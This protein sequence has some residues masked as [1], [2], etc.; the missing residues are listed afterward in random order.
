[1]WKQIPYPENHL[2]PRVL[3]KICL[4]HSKGAG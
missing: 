2:K 3:T 4:V 1:M